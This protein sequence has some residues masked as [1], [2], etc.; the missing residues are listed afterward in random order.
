MVHVR[1]DERQCCGGHSAEPRFLRNTTAIQWG[2]CEYLSHMLLFRFTALLEDKILICAKCRCI[3]I[4]IIHLSF[5][6]FFCSVLK[7]LCFFKP[8]HIKTRLK[9]SQRNNSFVDVLA[10]SFFRAKTFARCLNIM[11]WLNLSTSFAVF[12]VLHFLFVSATLQLPLSPDT[13]SPA[14]VQSVCALHFTIHT[15]NTLH[16]PHSPLHTFHTRL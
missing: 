1:K 15:H 11:S 4:P 9:V 3:H 2:S 12:E 10:V 13:T 16:A 8:Y 5:E 7:Q 14:A 6:S